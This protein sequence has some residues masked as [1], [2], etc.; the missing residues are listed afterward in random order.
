[1]YDVD[2]DDYDDW[3]D[4]IDDPKPVVSC[5]VATVLGISLLLAWPALS[6]NAAIAVL[7]F[8]LLGVGGPFLFV[9]FSLKMGGPQKPLVRNFGFALPGVSLVSIG[10]IV[11]HIYKDVGRPI[12]TVLDIAMI[13]GGVWLL[14]FITWG[15]IRYKVKVGRNR[16]DAL[17]G[18]DAEYTAIKGPRKRRFTL[19][20][21]ESLVIALLGTV[22][23]VFADIIALVR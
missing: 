5:A 3:W 18:E 14:A 10:M 6:L 23:C 11:R 8:L 2:D 7:G 1:M 12:I 15:I 16:P 4:F 19:Y 13:F 9:F 17:N 20:E 22:A 21:A